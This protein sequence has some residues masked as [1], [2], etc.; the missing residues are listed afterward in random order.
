VNLSDASLFFFNES[1][2]ELVRATHQDHK[3]CGVASTIEP[4]LSLAI[5]LGP[6]IAT[7]FKTKAN[8]R[9]RFVF[10]PRGRKGVGSLLLTVKK[11]M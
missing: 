4:F 2:S 10:S 7:T 8:V 5:F 9:V 6:K 3:T 11:G 1:V